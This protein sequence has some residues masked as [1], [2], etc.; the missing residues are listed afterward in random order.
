MYSSQ[1]LPG[2]NY[3]FQFDFGCTLTTHRVRYSRSGAGKA[4]MIS[5]MLENISS[6]QLHYKSWLLGLI[7]GILGMV[8]GAAISINGKSN[9]EEKM[10]SAGLIVS[11]IGLMLLLLYLTSRKHYITIS[12]KGGSAICFQT[13]GIMREQVIAFIDKVDEAINNRHASL[14]E[15]ALI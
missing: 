15:E 6:V 5:I 2:E 1:L 10:I 8:G 3:L 13:K 14:K 9:G 4:E 7:L 11:F 12:S